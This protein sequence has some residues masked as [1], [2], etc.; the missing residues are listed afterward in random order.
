MH[1]S[2]SSLHW[3]PWPGGLSVPS[4]GRLPRALRGYS[5]L[6]KG[7]RKK[8]MREF[9]RKIRWGLPA[10]LLGV[11]VPAFAEGETPA[12]FDTALTSLQ[13]GVTSMIDKVVPVVA[14]ILV[15]LLVF[16]GLFMAW[17]YVKKAAK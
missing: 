10:L 16:V 12:A 4:C 15:A 6:N 13:S 5:K 14:A 3:L 1:W 8:Q 9:L 7:E 17:R 2:F 11:T